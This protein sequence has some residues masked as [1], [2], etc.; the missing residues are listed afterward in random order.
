MTNTL[1][2]HE[3]PRTTRTLTEDQWFAKAGGHVRW[4]AAFHSEL[5]KLEPRI[6]KAQD[7]QT[8]QRIIERVAAIERRAKQLKRVMARHIDRAP[9]ELLPIVRDVYDFTVQ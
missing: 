4:K 3:Q 6:A 7:V 2:N 9:A 1:N 8:V 5:A